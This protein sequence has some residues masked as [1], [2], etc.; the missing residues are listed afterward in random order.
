MSLIASVI[1]L[2]K[3]LVTLYSCPFPPLFLSLSLAILHFSELWIYKRLFS[4]SDSLSWSIRS[5]FQNKLHNLSHSIA[6]A[7]SFLI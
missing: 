4:V 2:I 6:V 3:L 1:G 5:S 7:S